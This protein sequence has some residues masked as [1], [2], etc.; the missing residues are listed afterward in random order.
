MKPWK[1][2]GAAPLSRLEVPVPC[3]VPPSAIGEVAAAVLALS[4]AF[5]PFPQPRH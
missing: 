4:A 5:V 3:L 2:R 1:K